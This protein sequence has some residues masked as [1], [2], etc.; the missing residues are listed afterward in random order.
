MTEL[1]STASHESQTKPRSRWSG[2]L[3]G[4]HALTS[5]HPGAGTALGTVDLPIQ[6]ERHTDWPNIAGSAQKGIL[7]DL[8]REQRK[9]NHNDDPHNG[10]DSSQT[11]PRSRRRK[12][13]EEADVEAIFGPRNTEHAGALSITDA[14]LLAFPIRSLKGIFAWVTCPGVIER[15]QRD[16]SLL[17]DPLPDDVDLTE[18]QKQGTESTDFRAIT[19]DHCPC[20]IDPAGSGSLLL[21]EHRLE[22]VNGKSEPLAKWIAERLFPSGAHYQATRDRFVKQFIV[23]TDNDFTYFVRH[24]TEVSARIALDYETKTVTGGAL[25]YQEFLPTESLFYSVILM[26]EARTRGKSDSGGMYRDATQLLTI[27]QECLEN[28]EVLQIGGD[29]TTGKGYCSARLYTNAS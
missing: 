9:I 19:S 27:L 11:P 10:N 1:N 24:C 22:K 7:R 28:N 21:E 2:G 15:L 8:L 20:L 3:L 18:L 14:R 12:A 17:S 6:R 16:T 25:F 29:E 26:N 13:D 4:L 5:L 23:V